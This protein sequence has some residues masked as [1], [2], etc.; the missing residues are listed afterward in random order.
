M[1][2]KVIILEDNRTAVRAILDWLYLCVDVVV[3]A[4][5]GEALARRDEIETAEVIVLDRDAPDGSFHL[6]VP[7]AAWPRVISISS[8]TE[9]NLR[10]V[11]R[12]AR[13]VVPKCIGDLGGWARDVADRVN[14]ALGLCTCRGR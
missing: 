12:G 7:P 6:A 10:A 8:V 1:N 14:C 11:E 3:C 2:G 13:V 4:N 5:L 9:H